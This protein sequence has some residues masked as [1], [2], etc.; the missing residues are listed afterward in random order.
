MDNVGMGLGGLGMWE[1]LMIFAVV[2]L[3]LSAKRE[4]PTGF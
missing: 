2:L 1:M 4:P 3:L